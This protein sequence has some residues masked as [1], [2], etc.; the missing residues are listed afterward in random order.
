MQWT[1]QRLKRL[2]NLYP[3]YLG[4]GVRIHHVDPNWLELRVSMRLRWYNKNALGTH[5]G[6]SLYAMVDPHL[7]LLLLGAL[8]RDYVVWDQSAHIDFR[9][10]GRGRVHATIRLTPEDLTTIHVETAEGTPYRPTFVIDI[11]DERDDLIARVTKVLYIRR[12]NAA[13]S[14]KDIL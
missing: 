8:G 11:L 1:P 12:K 2:L 4:A 5:F 7:V 3:P 14:D 9:K 10:P 6:G 13:S